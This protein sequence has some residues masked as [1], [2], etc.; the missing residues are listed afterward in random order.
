MENITLIRKLRQSIEQ[1]LTEQ[2]GKKIVLFPFGEGGR[3]AKT[4]LEDSYGLSV[5]VIL[6]IRLAAY[7]PNIKPI[8]YLDTLVKSEYIVFYT[9]LSDKLYSVL[10]EHFP[11]DRVY[12]TFYET[13][14]KKKQTEC[15]K[16]SYGPLTDHFLVEKVGAFSSFAEGCDVVQ[17]H[18]VDYI[19][20]SPF[21]YHDRLINPAILEQ[22]S[23]CM[24]SPWYFEGVQPKGKVRN[25]RRIT[26]GNDVVLTGADS[27]IE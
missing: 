22:Y 11:E 19:S 2:K 5:D 8:T 17:N 25:L 18:A 26:I 6:D 23:E 12:C 13:S 15:G 24:A 4:I 20:V 16:Y 27:G 9:M 1:A 7:N 14:D 3:L 10:L 21:I